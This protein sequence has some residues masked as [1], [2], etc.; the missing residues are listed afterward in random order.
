M[1]HH[2]RKGKIMNKLRYIIFVVT[3]FLVL[4]L[5]AMNTVPALAD[6]STPPPTETPL[7]ET[8]PTDAA[9]EVAPPVEEVN[10][11]VDEIT[12][13]EETT[14]ELLT[15]VPEGTELVIVNEEGETIPLVTQEAVDAITFIDPVGVQWE[16]FLRMVSVGVLPLLAA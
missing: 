11:I 8:P 9:A 2:G 16:L 4:A 7:A 1:K 3:V 10:S 12:P 5:S 6:D 13:V 14:A 15:Q